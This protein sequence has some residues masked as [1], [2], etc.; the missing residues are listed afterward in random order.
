MRAPPKVALT[1]SQVASCFKIK[2]VANKYSSHWLPD[3]FPKPFY[4]ENE[5]LSL[6]VDV[7]QV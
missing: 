1:L 4:A 6:I 5:A 7:L 2:A 3:F